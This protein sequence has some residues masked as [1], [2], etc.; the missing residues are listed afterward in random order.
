MGEGHPTSL[1][2]KSLSKILVVLLKVGPFF[3]LTDSEKILFV[4]EN[5]ALEDKQNKTGYLHQLPV[6]AG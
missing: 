1:L 2:S 5:T 4:G 6:L 3:V